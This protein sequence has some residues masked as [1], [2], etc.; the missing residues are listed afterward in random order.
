MKKT[1]KPVAVVV[2]HR[3]GRKSVKVLTE[4][5]EE[6]ET[7]YDKERKE[8]AL[9]WWQ[10]MCRWF[11]NMGTLGIVLLIIALILFPGATVTFMISRIRKL[12]GAL[13][14]IVKAVK[15]S[16]A[17]ESDKDLHDSLSSNLS[18]KSKAL[19]GKIKAEL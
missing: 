2:K 4:R 13:R 9:S 7:T 6:R 12:G 11:G 15:E 5:S 19:V 10:R 17:V 16:K 1:S 8:P 14:E 3:G 18:R